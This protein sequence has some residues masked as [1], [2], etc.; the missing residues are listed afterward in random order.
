MFKQRKKR[1]FFIRRKFF[2]KMIDFKI[3]V[4]RLYQY[5]S[6]VEKFYRISN[7]SKKYIKCVRLSYICDFA[8]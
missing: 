2:L 6:R 1:L 4:I 3:D 8:F 7:D 5:C